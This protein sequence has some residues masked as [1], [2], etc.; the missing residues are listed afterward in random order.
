[1]E[2][3]LW[4]TNQISYTFMERCCTHSFGTYHS[5]AGKEK[6]YL[7][8]SKITKFGCDWFT[9]IIMIF[10]TPY[11]CVLEYERHVDWWT[12]HLK[13]QVK[14]REQEQPIDSIVEMKDCTHWSR[15][16][17][18]F[19]YHLILLIL[20]SDVVVGGFTQHPA[21]SSKVLAKFSV[22]LVESAKDY[23]CFI[24]SCKARER[25]LW[26]S[27]VFFNV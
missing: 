1:M 17:G 19:I 13:L 21:Q 7:I 24:Y 3:S 9:R 4:H 12:K 14:P 11:F 18:I 26:H 10:F 27:F 23:Y 6:R 20:S 16:L 15:F 25:G 2:K 22:N 5:R 8:Q